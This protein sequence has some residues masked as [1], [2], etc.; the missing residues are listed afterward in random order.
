MP[1]EKS[2]RTGPPRLEQLALTAGFA[3]ALAFV[4]TLPFP[5]LG[6]RSEPQEEQA[7]IRGFAPARTGAERQLENR[8][9]ALPDPVRAEKELEFLTSAPHLAGTEASRRIAW[10]LRDTLH[11]YGFDAQVVAYSIWLPKPV[12]LQLQMT[13]PEKMTLA[14]PEEP[15]AEDPATNDPHAVAG[16]AAYSAAGEVTAPVVY[17]NYGLPEDYDK[18]AE[19]GVKVA[20]KLALARYGS[21]YRGVKALVAEEHKCAALVLYSDPADDGYVQGDPFPKGPWRPMSGIQRGSVL[22]IF[23][24]PGDPLAPGMPIAEGGKPGLRPEDAPSLPHIPVLPISAR[25]AAEL[26]SRL[27]GPHVPKG[28]QGGLPFTYHAGPGEAVAH[29]Q[30]K[31]DPRQVRMLYDVIGRLPGDSD[32]EWVIAGNHHDAW[33]RGAVDPGSGTAS[34]LETAHALGTLAK[35]GWKP[36][37]S[38]IVA[39]WDGEEPGLLGSTAWAEA[40]QAELQ[41]KATV[42]INLDVAVSGPHFGASGTPSLAPLV[43]DVT[44][45]VQ[46]PQTGKSV[47]ETWQQPQAGKTQASPPPK[48]EPELGELGSGSDFT[49]FFEHLGVPSAELGF[50]G[51]YGVYHS[52]YDDLFWMKH[53]G[54][55]RF[56]YHAAMARIMGLLLLRMAD[57]D[58][59]PFDY[60]AYAITIENAEK[61]LEAAARGQ[62]A[63]LEFG[64]LRAAVEGMRESAARAQSTAET[65]TSSSCAGGSCQ[66]LNRALVEVEQALL[67]PGGL[68][69]RPWY[70]HT[71]YAPGTYTGY[72]AVLLPGV[73]E[74]LD[75]KDW[76]EAEKEMQ[77]LETA[78]LRAKQKLDEVAQSNR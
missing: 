42:Y 77:K 72:A 19:F 63:P 67:A 66:R 35:Q 2:R 7:R 40:H 21:G 22:Y 76:Q 48:S 9:Q 12:D 43:R 56:V 8:F 31:W 13:A 16:M 53:F 39:F 50:A 61:Q 27:D 34:L 36:R 64:S 45:E 18:L 33:V 68:S 74:A 37:R 73:R 28:W 70:R 51:D 54:D 78:L 59:L 55:P 69:R 6:S 49:P 32:D 57:A 29:L 52:M 14:R 10:H 71:I 1:V 65:I 46:D 58:V 20:G 4:A 17:V 62:G 44:R 47:L 5:A 11:S 26:L 24:Y 75:A 30:V 60:A 38:V 25:D 15:I 41:H 3:A 23:R